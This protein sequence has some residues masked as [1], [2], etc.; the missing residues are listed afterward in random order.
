MSSPRF[1]GA[2]TTPDEVP[3]QTVV[4]PPER[5]RRPILIE[6]ASAILI[7]GGLTGFAGVLSVTGPLQVLVLTINLLTIVVGILIRAGRGWVL[8]INVVVI[9]IFLEITALGTTFGI[10]F[11]ALDSIVLFALLRHRPWFDWQPD[12]DGIGA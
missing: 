9:A 10:V 11:L 1:E 8:A 12:G 2:V 4:P 3:D 7:V 6:V 5:P